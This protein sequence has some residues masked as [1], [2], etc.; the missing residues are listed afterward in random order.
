MNISTW[1]FLIYILLKHMRF[2]LLVLSFSSSLFCKEIQ[3]IDYIRVSTVEPD[4]SKELEDAYNND[5]GSKSNKEL[6]EE[7]FVDEAYKSIAYW[8]GITH[9]ERF[10]ETDFTVGLEDLVN[11]IISNSAPRVTIDDVYEWTH[12]ENSGTTYEYN[13]KYSLLVSTLN[14]KIEELYASELSYAENLYELSK[15]PEDNYTSSYLDYGQY[16]DLVKRKQETWKAYMDASSD[17]RY[18]GGGSGASMRAMIDMVEKQIFR[19]NELKIIL[20]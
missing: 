14:D 8:E 10:D 2:L 11:K 5:E 12:F 9:T 15:D 3:P 6:S 20:K 4:T 1:I 19:L 18:W 13:Q 7:E 17:E 16:V